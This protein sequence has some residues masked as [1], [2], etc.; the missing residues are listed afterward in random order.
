MILVMTRPEA[1]R[2]LGNQSDHA[3]RQ[4]RWALSLRGNTEL[5]DLKLM[6]CYTILRTPNRARLTYLATGAARATRLLDQW[7]AA[8]A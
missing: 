7:R 6:A 4:Q 3:T 2:I 8:Q 5:D 1:R